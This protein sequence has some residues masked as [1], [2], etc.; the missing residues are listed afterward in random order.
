MK[1]SL[2]VPFCEPQGSLDSYL[3]WRQLHWN[4]LKADDISALVNLILKSHILH[5]GTEVRTWRTPWTYCLRTVWKDL[6]YWVVPQVG[7]VQHL[8]EWCVRKGSKKLP[9]Q[10]NSY[11]MSSFG[12]HCCRLIYIQFLIKLHALVQGDKLAHLELLGVSTTMSW[13]SLLQLFGN[14]RRRFENWM[15]NM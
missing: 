6:S 14:C 8:T 4:Q 10:K 2:K 9:H 1:C 13:N 3:K 7:L 11:G 12:E 5:I 15:F